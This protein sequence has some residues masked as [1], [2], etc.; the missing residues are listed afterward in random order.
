[1]VAVVTF[2]R[3]SEGTEPADTVW[4]RHAVIAALREGRVHKLWLQR[5]GGTADDIL[6]LAR[7][8]R[9]VFQWVDR[10][11]IA[12]MAPG[13]THQGVVARV[14]PHRL[15]VLDDL[16]AKGRPE[17]LLVLDGIT[18]PHNLGAIVRSA[19]FFGAGGVLIPR[20]RSAGVTGVTA[21]AAA[22][23]LEV[24]P[25]VQV[26]NTAQTLL[27]LK[28]KGYWVYGA[29]AAGTSVA[30]MDFARPAVL[31]IGA[32]G[33]GL[34]RLVRERCDALVGIPG[35]GGVPSLNASCASAAL[36]Y[37]FYRRG[38]TAGQTRPKL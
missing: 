5:G 30:T 26:P 21:K 23:A 15:A 20:W 22:G 3:R 24:V 28:E 16:W 8:H 2:S 6:P 10:A 4:G 32:E 14:S 27:D 18:D 9:I 35:A 11:R 31:V 29:D 36:L 17:L 12:A 19:A 7:E 33:E 1:V 37:E 38:L 25:L 13:Q 34:H